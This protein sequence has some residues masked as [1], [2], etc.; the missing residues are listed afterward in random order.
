MEYYLA[1]L[2]LPFKMLYE[3]PVKFYK[4]LRDFASIMKFS[5]QADEKTLHPSEIRINRIEILF[6]LMKWYKKYGEVNYSFFEYSMDLKN[7]N[8]RDQ[9]IGHR[10]FRELRDSMNYHPHLSSED[11]YNYLC[12]VRDKFVFSSYL[13]SFDLPVVND[14][15]I[16]NSQD[17]HWLA[18]NK[19]F[20]TKLFFTKYE[21]TLD[22][23]CKPLGGIKGKGVF[24]FKIVDRMIVINGLENNYSDFEKRIDGDYIL[25]E[26]IIQHPLM[27]NIYPNSVNTIRIVTF[28]NDG[29]P[30]LFMGA[31]RIGSNG[32]NVDNLS[33]GGIAVGIDLGSGK[34]IENGFYNKIDK[35]EIIYMHPDT[36]IKFKDYELPWFQ[37]TK[38][39]LIKAHHWMYGFHSIGW[40]VA[41]TPSGPIIIEANDEW[42]GKIFMWT[43]KGFNDKFLKYYNL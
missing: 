12:L 35:P 25:Q 28:Y 43:H 21:S 30:E 29:N 26:R 3:W 23:F 33:E 19:K 17:L 42:G 20:N 34:L 15:A 22:A 31:L 32:R 4:K 16:F 10:K 5:Y 36:G 38:E 18:S 9:Y 13:S 2:K 1:A 40:D 41:I 11:C 7:D 39:L 6:H 14:L 27:W 8:S 37:E 24:S